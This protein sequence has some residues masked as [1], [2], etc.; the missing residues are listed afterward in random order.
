[1]YECSYTRSAANDTIDVDS[2]GQSNEIMLDGNGTPIET[3][4]GDGR[5]AEQAA[6]HGQTKEGEESQN[7]NI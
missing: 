3:T 1:M 7:S 4:P 6:P 5:P 2:L